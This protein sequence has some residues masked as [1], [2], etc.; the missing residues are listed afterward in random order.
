MSWRGTGQLQIFVGAHQMPAQHPFCKLLVVW[1]SWHALAVNNFSM[2]RGEAE[3][4][5]WWSATRWGGVRQR[6]RGER[7]WGREGVV[8]PTD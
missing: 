2:D 6:D 5:P 8:T 4:R 3:G 7:I 1:H